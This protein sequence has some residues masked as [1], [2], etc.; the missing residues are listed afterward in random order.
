MLFSLYPHPTHKSKNFG[1]ISTSCFLTH[2]L[3]LSASLSSIHHLCACL[4][5]EKKGRKRAINLDDEERK[6]KEEAFRYTRQKEKRG[7]FS[8]QPP[9]ERILGLGGKREK[10]KR[11]GEEIG[12]LS[13]KKSRRR[14]RRKKRR[15]RMM[16]L[17][18]KY[19]AKKIRIFFSVVGER[20]WEALP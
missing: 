13:N 20:A 17:F 6:R 9:I 1:G 14:R 19:G 8:Q 7:S 18:I 2:G 10:G 16:M 12:I 5:L 15:K 4:R 11:R 3:S